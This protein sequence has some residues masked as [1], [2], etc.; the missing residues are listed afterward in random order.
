MQESSEE[1]K[2]FNHWVYHK[3]STKQMRLNEKGNGANTVTKV[4]AATFKERQG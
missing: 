3:K 1:N 4:K 2:Y